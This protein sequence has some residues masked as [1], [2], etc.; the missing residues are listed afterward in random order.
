MFNKPTYKLETTFIFYKE[1]IIQRSTS[2]AISCTARTIRAGNSCVWCQY[3]VLADI[4]TK[5]GISE[6][7]CS[8]CFFVIR[9]IKLY[10]LCQLGNE[11]AF[12]SFFVRD[13][14]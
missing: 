9:T 5:S 2:T 10:K 3:S 7:L 1:R 6:F 14:Q 13:C 8:T 4:A 11:T 12:V